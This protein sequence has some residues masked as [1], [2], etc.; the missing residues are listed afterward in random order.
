MALWRIRRASKEALANPSWQDA[1]GNVTV[2]AIKKYYVLQASPGPQ[3]K[4]T[5]FA[6]YIN[7]SGGGP[8]TDEK[9]RIT[10][11]SGTPYTAEESSRIVRSYRK[12]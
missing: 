5:S 9:T 11:E 7:G 12:A 3:T 10:T 6:A 2:G 1:S 8:Q 4:Q